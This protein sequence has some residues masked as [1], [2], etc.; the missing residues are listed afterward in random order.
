MR[1]RWLIDF[2]GCVIPTL[3]T[4]VERINSEYETSFT[5]NNVQD[6]T[7]FWTTVPEPLVQW[8]WSARCFDNPT[9]LDR[10][11][12]YPHAIESIQAL[13]NAECPVVIVTDR[14]V[15][16]LPWIRK[17]FAERNLVLPIVSSEARNDNK[18]AYVAEYQITT[19]IEDSASHAA[20]Y[21]TEPI[22]KLFLFS[23]PW[24]RRVSLTPPAER[25]DSWTD[26]YSRV[27]EENPA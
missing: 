15:R 18:T 6:I 8:A 24:N 21:L 23:T 25:L 9:F 19:V 5:L 12:A 10:V 16:H 4:L 20:Q 14:P 3:S 7:E 17:W 22:Q 26:L 11:E 1:T 2:D 27:K 13:L